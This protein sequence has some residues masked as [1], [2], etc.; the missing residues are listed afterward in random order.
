MEVLVAAVQVQ[1]AVQALTV[2]LI[3]KEVT[4]TEFASSQRTHLHFI[5]VNIAVVIMLFLHFGFYPLLKIAVP[6]FLSVKISTSRTKY[7]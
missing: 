7:T 4:K 6:T 1:A 2:V 5:T 3:L